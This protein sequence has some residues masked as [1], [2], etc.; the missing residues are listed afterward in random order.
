MLMVK[1]EDYLKRAFHK[2]IDQGYSVDLSNALAKR[3]LA[4]YKKKWKQY[5]DEIKLARKGYKGNNTPNFD[6][7]DAF[8]AKEADPKFEKYAQEIKKFNLK[9]NLAICRHYGMRYSVLN[10]L[11]KHSIYEIINAWLSPRDE[12]GRLVF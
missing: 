4:A 8:R 3:D 7:L 2:Y 10:H 5:S 12:R 9:S 6:P 1:D 11:T